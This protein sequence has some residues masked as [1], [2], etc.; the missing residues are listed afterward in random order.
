[1]SIVG[2]VSVVR[3]AA[4]QQPV[5]ES[6]FKV[7]KKRK[8]TKYKSV[9]EKEYIVHRQDQNIVQNA[10]PPRHGAAVE[11]KI[12]YWTFDPYY[13]RSGEYKHR[14]DQYHLHGVAY[15][16]PSPER[17]QPTHFAKDFP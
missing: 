7:P 1:M 3:C 9:E 17:F 10:G 14:Q 8:L 2:L 15:I 13:R 4:P 16:P 5:K 6:L 12:K 11:Q